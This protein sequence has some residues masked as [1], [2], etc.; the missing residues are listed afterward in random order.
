MLRTLRTMTM[1][2]RRWLGF[3]LLFVFFP[4]N[5]PLLETLFI[6]L[7][8]QT[9]GVIFMYGAFILGAVLLFFPTKEEMKERLNSVEEEE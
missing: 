9:P 2:A 1:N 5:F 6:H 4:V 8:G 3:V 7:F